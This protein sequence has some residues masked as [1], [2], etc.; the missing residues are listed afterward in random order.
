[1]DD[2]NQA[3]LA[4]Q[5]RGALVGLARVGALGTPVDFCR[6]NILEPVNGTRVGGCFKLLVG[7]CTDDMAMALCLAD[8]SH[9]CTKSQQR[10]ETKGVGRG[11]IPFKLIRKEL[12]AL[13]VHPKGHITR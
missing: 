5:A 8:T 11:I 2:C 6:L 4:G 9:R 1:M 10:R 7:D 3:R 13:M 12:R